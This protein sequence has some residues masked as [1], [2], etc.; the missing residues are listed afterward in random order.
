MDGLA[1]LPV[2]KKGLEKAAWRPAGFCGDG[3]WWTSPGRRSWTAGQP[4]C[5]RRPTWTLRWRS[6]RLVSSTG[7][8]TSSDPPSPPP[9][10]CCHPQPFRGSYI[11]PLDALLCGP[12]R[13]APELLACLRSSFHSLN[14]QPATIATVPALFSIARLACLHAF[15]RQVS[16]IGTGTVRE[17]FHSTFASPSPRSDGARTQPRTIS[18]CSQAFS[19]VHECV[20]STYSWHKCKKEYFCR[21]MSHPCTF[22]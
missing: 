6:R 9:H 22:Y 21:T 2:K 5:P 12:L 1:S 8:R 4:S 15:C 10:R 7:R 16:V 20:Q 13:P 19:P 18:Q 3:S 17:S 14:S 11:G